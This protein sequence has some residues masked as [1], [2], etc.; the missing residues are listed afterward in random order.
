[1]ADRVL[2]HVGPAF[3]E[4][5]VRILRLARFAARFGDFRVD[6]ETEKLLCTM[7]DAGEVDALVPERVW[8]EL[9][10]GLMERQPSRLFEVLHGCGALARLLPEL[11]RVWNERSGR[12]IDAAALND[13]PLDVRWALLMIDLTSAE[14]YPA[15]EAMAQT[16][17]RP[18]AALTR[19]QFAMKTVNYYMESTG[20]PVNFGITITL[21]FIVGLAIT[22]QTFYLFVTENIRQ[23]GALKAMGVDNTRLVGMILLQGFVAGSTGYGLGIGLAAC[24][25]EGTAHVPALE[26]F[27]MFPG[28]LVGIALTVMAIVTLASLLSIRKVLVLEPAMVFR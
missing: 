11:N 13:E 9:A 26:G 2:R 27:G 22:G 17:P 5:P 24:F 15:I 12:L 6:P 23:F 16:G 19:E 21:G 20:I 1:L 8:Q 28:L 7:V 14:D 10:R 3:S 18:L 25:F 4:D